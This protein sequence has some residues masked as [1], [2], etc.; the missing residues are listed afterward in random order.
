[1]TSSQIKALR[2]RLKLSG[3]DAAGKH[4][5]YRQLKDAKI[6]FQIEQFGSI[7]QNRYSDKKGVQPEWVG[8]PVTA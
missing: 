4:F 5:L 3:T 2:K 1:M 6:K 7:L 8:L